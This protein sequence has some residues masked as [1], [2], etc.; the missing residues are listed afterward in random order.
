MRGKYK[1]IWRRSW[2]DSFRRMDIIDDT[3]IDRRLTR[4]CFYSQSGSTVSLGI[5]IH[6]QYL[7]LQDG[8]AGT[9]IDCRRGLPDSS[10][11]IGNGYDLSQNA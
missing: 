2:N 9:H 4:C 6:Q 10:F 3:I 5:A 7:F 11:L 1:K 8:Q